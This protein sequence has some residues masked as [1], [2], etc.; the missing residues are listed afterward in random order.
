M[1]VANVHFGERTAPSVATGL[2]QHVLRRNTLYTAGAYMF[3][4]WFFSE[5]Y[6]FSAP[7]EAD[8]KWVTKSK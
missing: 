1:R 3:S 5:V 7:P 2:A 4:A 8:L 6:V